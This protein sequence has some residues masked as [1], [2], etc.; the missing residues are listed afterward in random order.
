MVRTVTFTRVSMVTSES[1]TAGSKLPF[2]ETINTKS[3][4]GLWIN[5]NVETVDFS[6]L[7]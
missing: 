6:S 1:N 5:A 4:D 2:G 7:K 3:S